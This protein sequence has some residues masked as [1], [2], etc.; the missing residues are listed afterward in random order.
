MKSLFINQLNELVDT[1][2]KIS[3]N[4]SFDMEKWFLKV[5]KKTFECG[6]VGCICGHQALSENNIYFEVNK[7]L[8]FEKQAIQISNQL[9]I[10]CRLLFHDDNLATSIYQGVAW[11]RRVHAYKTGLFTRIQLNHPHLSN[12]KPTVKQTINFI[13]LVIKKVEINL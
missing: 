12:K 5:D 8:T 4:K 6:F 2:T 3:K 11:S 1:L 7:N 9:S 13:K 10:S